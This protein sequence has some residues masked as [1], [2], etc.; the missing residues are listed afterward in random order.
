MPDPDA[1]DAH[2]SSTSAAPTRTATSDTPPS[3]LDALRSTAERVH[4]SARHLAYQPS[5]T[6]D[7]ALAHV[8]ASLRRHTESILEANARDVE[9]GR[10][11]G[12]DEAFL[13]RLQLTSQRVEKMAGAVEELLALDDPVGKL[14]EMWTRPNGLR[15]GKRRIPLGVIGI[16]YESRPNVTSDAACLCLKSG[17]GVLLKGGSDAFE[18]NRAIFAAIRAGLDASALPDEAS[19]AVGFVDTRERGAVKDMLGMDA[20]VDVIIPRGGHGLIEFVKENSRIPV[21]KHDEGVCHVVVDGTALPDVVDRVVL[22]AKTQRTGV[23]NAAETLLLTTDGA[24]EHGVRVLA[25]LADAGVKMHLCPRSMELATGAEIDP[26]LLVEAD[27]DA[28]AREFLALELS[29]RVV[30]DLTDAISHIDTFGSRHTEALLTSDYNASERFQAEVDSSCVV[31][32]ASTRF[33]DG[34]ELGLGAEI[35]ISTTKMHAYGPMGLKELTTTKFVVL[36]N[37]QIRQ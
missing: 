26:S 10:E 28:F 14:D 4:R 3:Y 7:D 29:V 16:I 37:G 13:D 20:Y 33:N 9:R 21:I 5:A 19:A 1:T 23:C 18:S 34:G 35:G 32:N 17:N 15:V 24:R 27:N 36:G 2:T 30:D 11:K 12:L 22:N 31:I 8:A 6:K 25:K